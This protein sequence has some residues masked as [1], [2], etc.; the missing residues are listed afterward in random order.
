M[1]KLRTRI[2]D[3]GR[4][5]Q[6][7]QRVIDAAR[8]LFSERGFHATGIAQIAAQSGVLVGQIYRDFENKEAIV[9]AIVEHD[10]AEFLSLES[11]SAAIDAGDRVAVRAWISHFVFGDAEK[12][13]GLA[14]EIMAEA[15]RNPR[16]SEISV[17]I[18]AQLRVALR[19]AI[20]MLLPRESHSRRCDE[21]VAVVT[22]LG[23][24]IFQR[25]LAE[26]TEPDPATIAAIDACIDRE[27]AFTG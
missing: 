26:R 22:S 15:A 6:R 27:L 25:R 18:H 9:A 5:D 3:L 17:A 12:D 19:H 14:A 11:L 20:G 7:R 13:H 23:S 24:G 1:T 10:L 16:I 4:A 2:Q 21:V 8:E